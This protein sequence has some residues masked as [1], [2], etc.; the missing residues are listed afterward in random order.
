[1]LVQL[2][3]A[4]LHLGRGADGPERVVLVRG[5]DAEHGHHRVADE[6]L[7]RAAVPLERRA[8]LLEVARHDPANR[9]GVDPLAAP[10]GVDDI[11]EEDGHGPA[12]LTPRARRLRE[13]GAARMTES[14]ALR[15]ALAAFRTG[16]HAT[17]LGTTCLLGK[18]R[19]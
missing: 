2:C 16:D 13:G 14:S 11:A 5:W 8:H 19:F 1:L 15:V 17:S 6:L 3:Q 4:R 18:K 7:D 10:G 9:L 12:R